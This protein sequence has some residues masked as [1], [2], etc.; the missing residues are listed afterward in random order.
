MLRAEGADGSRIDTRDSVRLSRD[1]VVELARW[2]GTRLAERSFG[3]SMRLMPDR[4]GRSRLSWD[5]FNGVG[6]SMDASGREDGFRSGDVIRGIGGGLGGVTIDQPRPDLVRVDGAMVGIDAVR[7]G[8]MNPIFLGNSGVFVD[9]G[10][11]GNNAGFLETNSGAVLFVSDNH[12]S[13]DER[14]ARLDARRA[15]SMYRDAVTND[16]IQDVGRFFLTR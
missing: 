14:M 2:R 7:N 12:R 10:I 6:N 3:D 1:D 9:A 13:G 16:S 8:A 15:I 5:D 4:T 11:P